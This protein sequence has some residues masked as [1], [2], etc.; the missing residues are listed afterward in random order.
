EE[1][2]LSATTGTQQCEKFPSFDPHGNALQDFLNPI[3]TA[4]TFA[5]MGNVQ[6]GLDRFHK[7][8]KITMTKN[9]VSLVFFVLAGLGCTKNTEKSTP[10]KP[11]EVNLAIWGNYFTKAEQERFSNLT[12][13]RLNITNYSS[14]EELL[15]KVQAGASGID[16]AVPSD[17]MVS[18]LI[19]M[20]ALEPLNK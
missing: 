10:N 16:V 7:K 19:K 8:G 15:A 2:R 18:I 1:S 9:L 17:Y 4:V 5:D 13:I 20:D 14:N 12:G 3:L 6:H 11:R